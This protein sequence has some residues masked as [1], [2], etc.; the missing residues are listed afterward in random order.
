MSQEIELQ[1]EK[2]VLSPQERADKFLKK[3]L[4]EFNEFDESLE[5]VKTFNNLII[6]DLDDKEGY[7][8]VDNHRKTA[9][10][11]KVNVENKR[12]ELVEIPNLITKA[13]NEKAKEYSTV[14]A[15][16]E[17][18][19]ELKTKWYE[20]EHKKIKEEEERIFRESIN[21]RIE[22]IQKYDGV[23]SFDIMSSLDEEEYQY[24]LAQTKEAFE[25]KEK[26]KA[27]LEELR[28]FKAE[29]EAKERARE[30]ELRKEQER[31]ADL[32]KAMQKIE[33]QED[34]EIIKSN[35]PDEEPNPVLRELNEKHIDNIELHFNKIYG[36]VKLMKKNGITENEKAKI[37]SHIVVYTNGINEI[38]GE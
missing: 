24:I 17:K 26:E 6:K 38:L 11:F 2:E 22:E 20:E 25:I 32:Q 4:K 1:Q 13:I 34:K 21:K 35:I 33:E 12:K 30:E 36:V 23:T 3:T 9:K 28:K 10:R 27:E 5:R 29:Q 18:E 15:S 16:V 7:N 37:L 8:A 14:F 31:E 19:L